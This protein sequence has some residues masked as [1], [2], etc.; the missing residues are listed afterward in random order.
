MKRILIIILFAGI[1]LQ[2]GLSQQ[3]PL[4]SQFM[5]NPYLINPALT[6]TYPYYQIITNNRLQ[7]VGFAD[8]PITNTISVY[9]P[10]VEQP[11]GVGGYIMQDRWGPTSTIN[12]CGTYAY[13]YGL[14]EDLKISMGLMLGMYQ[15]KMDGTDLRIAEE[16]KYFVPGEIYQNL[17]PDASLGF[18]LY[19]SVY[20]VGLSMTNLFGNKLKYDNNTSIEEADTN[21]S[22]RSTIGRVKQHVYLHGG[23]KYFINHEFA[24][25]PTLAIKK[26]AALP[27]Q[28]D[29]NARVWYGKRSW[30]GDKVWAGISYRTKDALNI[31]IGYIYQRKVEIGY[32]YDIT[33]NRTRV[34][35]SGSH[36]IMIGFKFNNIK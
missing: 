6:G 10:M 31:M 32:S 21:A 11:M 3:D 36:E 25:E 7:W 27:M 12:I 24:V 15:Y 26:V 9:G 1:A 16:D 13:N 4:Y 29:L 18:Y 28:L 5:T 17:E 35:Q 2:S 20:H 34:Y 30:N 8:A 22:D 19:S 23:Y 14:A 33:I